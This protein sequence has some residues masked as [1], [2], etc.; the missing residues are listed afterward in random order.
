MSSA[1][2]CGGDD[3]V[4]CQPVFLVVTVIV[5]SALD[6]DRGSEEFNMPKGLRGESRP[7]DLIGCAV[8]VAR[9]ATGEADD[10]RYA[11][12]VFCFFSSSKVASPTP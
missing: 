4:V 6:T 11:T 12:E 1:T 9:I 10:D 2:R 7:A 5:N 3:D 8:N